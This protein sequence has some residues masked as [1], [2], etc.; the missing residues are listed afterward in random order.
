MIRCVHPEALLAA[1]LVLLVLRARVWPRPFVGV[2]RVLALL[3]A[4]FLLAGPTW[5]GVADGRDVV[6]VVDRSLSMPEGAQ[7]KAREVAQQLDGVLLDGDRLGVVTFGRKPVVEAMPQAPFVWPASAPAVDGDASDLAAGIATALA[8]VPAG[9]NGS[10][11]VLSDG[12]HT[13]GSL[14]EVARA[15]LRQG[16]RIDTMHSARNPGADTAVV[17]VQAP[18]AVPVGEPF[19]L[20]AVAVATLAGEAT[21]RLLVDG[22]EVQR[23]NAALA[24]GRNVLQFRL[25]LAEP[26]Q[27][28]VAVEVTGAGDARPENDRATTVVRVE[29]PRRVL[30]VTQG[31]AEDRL[32]RALRAAGFAVVV[33]APEVAPL[34]LAQ[35]DGFRAVV[36]DDVPAGAL[37]AGAMRALAQWVR[38]LGGGLLMTGGKASF[39]VGGYHRSPIEDVLP[40]TME[41]REQQRRF[42]LAMAIALDRSGSMRADA[43]GV[44]KMDLAN[45][46][47]AAA[48]E[49]LSPIDAV[50]V[51]AVDTGPHVV[52][53]MTPVQ[54]KPGLAA[55]ARSIESEGGGIFV[56]VALHAAAEELARAPQQHKHLVLFAD[57]S[58]SEEPGDYATFV[59]ELVG[60][61]ITVSVIGLGS[62]ADSDAGLLQRIAELGKG[63]CQFVGDAAELPR[64][65][66]QETIQ[67]ARSSVV[68]APTAIAVKPAYATLGD[69]PVPFPDVGGYALAWP[70]TGAEQDLVTVDEQRAPFLCHWHVGLGRSAAFLGEADGAL[71]GAM[72]G[73]AQFGDCFATL[74][75]WL[76]GGQPQGLFV[77]ARAE[78]GTGVF[79]LEIEPERAAVLDDVRGVLALPGG[80]TREVGFERLAPGRLQARVPLLTTGVHRVAVQV[81]TDS[82]ALPPV[83]LP[84]SP[85]FALEP[86]PRAGERALAGLA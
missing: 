67:V 49:L 62:A 48:I 37:P 7:A 30:C 60:A 25:A 41:I 6:L 23:G 15:A 31:G 58:D 20:A 18:A 27:H 4:A 3:A 52:V 85:E 80:A 44:P 82:V 26:G 1:P 14:D 28:E 13:S 9:R 10:L 65:F 55:R 66:A 68:E 16:L 35:L 74:L 46:G 72:V 24:Q 54:D 71:S 29:A 40:V 36:L 51:L 32:T 38:D 86:D 59:P 76:A 81:G 63:R 5:Q 11:L 17:D 69:M 45:R 79:T 73:W 34:S 70:R 56:G 57:A 19:A 61:G 64:V 12:E 47:A 42:G 22:H 53:P 75:R 21:W 39:G 2:L 84:Y 50:A 78:G 83:C 33:T 43:G 77:S 8:L